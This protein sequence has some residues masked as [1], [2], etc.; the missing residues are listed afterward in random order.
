MIN[1]NTLSVGDYVEV[2]FTE[3][4]WSRGGHIKGIITKLWNDD[5]H[6]QAQVENGWCFHQCDK[7]IEHRK[8]NIV[9]TE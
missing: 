2:E 3:G 4:T 6:I 8:N 9:R 5:K 7:I 1:F